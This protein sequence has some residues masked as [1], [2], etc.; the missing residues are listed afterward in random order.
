MY[1]LVSVVLLL[2]AS[3]VAQAS[4]SQGSSGK[5]KL[6]LDVQNKSFIEQKQTIIAQLGDGKTYS[7]ISSKDRG[8]VTAALDRMD[9]AIGT[10]GSVDAL[11]M[12]QKVAVFNDQEVVNTLLTKARKDSRLVCKRETTVSSRLPTTQCLTVA[13]RKRVYEE[14]Q[15][16][17]RDAKIPTLQQ[18]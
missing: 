4:I 18:R 3:T 17:I 9:V 16:M 12:E 15:S 14:A 8:E 6:E 13:E 7:E 2:A 1:K 10:A 11:T 5:S